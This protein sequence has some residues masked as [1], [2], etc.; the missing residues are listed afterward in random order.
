MDGLI[1]KNKYTFNASK[2]K[3]DHSSD[4]EEDEEEDNDE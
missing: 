4:E 2:Q 1:K 3:I